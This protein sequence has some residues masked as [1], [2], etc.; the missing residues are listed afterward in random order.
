MRFAF[1][2]LHRDTL[3]DDAVVFS[4]GELLVQLHPKREIQQNRFI[5]TCHGRNRRK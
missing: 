2:P 4:D 3:R 5:K 1:I